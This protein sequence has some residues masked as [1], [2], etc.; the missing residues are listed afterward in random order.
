MDIKIN[1]DKNMPF[2]L[3]ILVCLSFIYSPAFYAGKEY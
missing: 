3:P 2:T 1:M